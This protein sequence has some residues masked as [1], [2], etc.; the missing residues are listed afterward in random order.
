[1]ATVDVQYSISGHVGNAIQDSVDRTLRPSTTSAGSDFKGGFHEEGFTGDSSGNVHNA[2]PGP[3]FKPTDSEAHVT[4]T[5]TSNTRIIEHTHPPG[6]T[7]SNTFGGTHFDQEPSPADRANAA[8]RP[9]VTH[10]VAGVGDKT[11]RFYN[12]NGTQATIPLN[13]FPKCNNGQNCH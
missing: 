3:A 7:G 2:S 13:A 9:G 12:G 10:I 11:V 6:T 8:N 5:V 1:M 4:Q